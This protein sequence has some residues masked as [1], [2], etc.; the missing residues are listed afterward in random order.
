MLD[1]YDHA[2]RVTEAL[3]QYRDPLTGA[4]DAH[5]A[6]ESNRLGRA[7][8]LLTVASIVLMTNALV[9]AIY[10]MN[11]EHMPEPGWVWGYPF[12]LGPM[13][14]LSA[15]LVVMFRRRGWL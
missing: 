10:G 1:L 15:L 13:A 14:A 4:L 12:A 2:V 8:K 11:F 6:Y 7:V 5:L 3:D 9:A